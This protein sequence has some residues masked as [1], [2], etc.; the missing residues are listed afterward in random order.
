MVR[1]GL[2]GGRVAPFRRRDRQPEVRTLYE[3]IAL[4]F[5]SI[6]FLPR[7]AKLST[8]ILGDKIGA[9]TD[10]LKMHGRGSLNC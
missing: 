9:L 3:F 5:A 8:A 10:A 7:G 2:A 1:V 4:L 6:A